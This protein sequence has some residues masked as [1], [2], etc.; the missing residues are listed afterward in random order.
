MAPRGGVFVLT[1]VL[2]TFGLTIADPAHLMPRWTP[3]YA[4]SASTIIQP[5]N[6]SGTMDSQWLSKWGLVSLS[7]CTLKL[8]VTPPFFIRSAWIGP[9]RGQNGL[10]KSR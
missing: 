3:T 7:S 8:H 2:L 9:M 10:K 5:C 4:M 6:W 1:C